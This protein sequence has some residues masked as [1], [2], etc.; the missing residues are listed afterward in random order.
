V[1][2]IKIRGVIYPYIK[3]GWKKTKESM[4]KRERR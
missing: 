3:E 1:K 2:D 4:E